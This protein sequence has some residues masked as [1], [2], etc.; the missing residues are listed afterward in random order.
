MKFDLGGIGRGRDCKTVNLI[1]NCDIQSDILDLDS[2]CKDDSVDEFLM[3]H[4][5]E[6][7]SPA[8]IPAFLKKILKKLKLT[9]CLRI[10]HTDAKKT[11]DLYNKS[12]IDFKSLRSIVFTPLDV[13]LRCFEETQKD[14]QS[15][16]FMWGVDELKEE[17][18]F[19]GFKD[20]QEF[21]AGSWTFDINNY[22]ANDKMT[23]FHGVKIPNLGIVAYK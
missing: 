18:L 1:K 5:Y 11:I 9:G 7:I 22:F 6:H 4:T 13:R 17:L 12:I 21:D 14:L 23:S 10:L 16:Q 2:F 3:T 19:Y 15:H 20:V 8:V